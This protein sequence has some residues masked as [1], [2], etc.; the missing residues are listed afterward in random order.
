MRAIL[1]RIPLLLLTMFVSSVLIFVASEILPIDVARNILGQFAPQEAVDV[2]NHKLGFDQPPVTRY[3]HWVGRALTGDFGMSTSQQSRVGPLILK[4]AATVLDAMDAVEHELRGIPTETG[5]VRLG[6][7]PSVG[8]VILP[9]ALTIL[10]RAHPGIAVATREGSTPSL[11]RSLRAGTLDVAVLAVGPPFRAPDD[12]KPALVVQTLTDRELC[13][14][15]SAADPLAD[16]DSVHVD[17]LA[18]RRWVAS[19]SSGDEPLLGAWPGLPERPEVAHVARDWL[20]K[21]NLVAA[22]CGLTTVP[23][24]M[25]AAV[26]PGVRV[27]TVRGGPRESR[28]LIAAHLPGRQPE[29]VAR[30]LAALRA[31]SRQV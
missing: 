26:P 17:E 19:R 7:I 18:G 25:I 2:L 5:Y 29:P 4:H 14:A 22:G 11:V 6:A 21:L 31:A 8:A 30:V 16:N 28:R 1:R 24:S 13:V 9:R 20:T 23:A 15:V 3:L 12:E 10:R 27:L